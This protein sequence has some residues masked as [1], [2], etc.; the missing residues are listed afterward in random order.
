MRRII[1]DALGGLRKKIRC[2][3]INKS[4]GNREVLV[5]NNLMAFIGENTYRLHKS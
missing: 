3:V 2:P 1:N 4:T 5:F